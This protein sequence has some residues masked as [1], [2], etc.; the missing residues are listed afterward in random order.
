MPRE[1]PGYMLALHDDNLIFQY[2]C[3]LTF[4]IWTALIWIIFLTSHILRGH[5]C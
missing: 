3:Y 4:V 5:Y 1:S 2:Y